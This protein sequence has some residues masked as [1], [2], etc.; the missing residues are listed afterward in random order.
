MSHGIA[1]ILKPLCFFAYRTHYL[2]PLVNS[3]YNAIKVNFY[4]LFVVLE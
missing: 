4:I 3:V 1:Y 2:R